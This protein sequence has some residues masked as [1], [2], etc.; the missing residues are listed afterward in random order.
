MYRLLSADTPPKP[1]GDWALTEIERRLGLISKYFGLVA[2]AEVR[3]ELSAEAFLMGKTS[4]AADLLDG[5]T[6]NESARR[7]LGDLR[8]F[9]TGDGGTLATPQ[10]AR[11]ISAKGLA[12]LPGIAA[13]IPADQREQWKAPKPPADTETTLAKLEKDARKGVAAVLNSE[14]DR[15]FKRVRATAETIRGELAKLAGPLALF[16]EKVKARLGRRVELAA[17]KGLIAFLAARGLTVDDAVALLAADADRPAQVAR[18]LAAALTQPAPSFAAHIGVSARPP[19]SLGPGA[20]GTFQLPAAIVSRDRGKIRDAARGLLDRCAEIGQDRDSPLRADFEREI[21]RMCGSGAGESLTASEVVQGLLD[22]SRDLADDHVW[23]VEELHEL[24]RTLEGLAESDFDDPDDVTALR[25]VKAHNDTLTGTV[26]QRIWAVQ[27]GCDLLGQYGTDA[28]P[29]LPWLQTAA[30]GNAPWQRHAA[31][32]VTKINAKP[33][34]VPKGAKPPV[35]CVLT[36]NPKKQPLEAEAFTVELKNNT[37]EAIELYSTLPFGTLVFMDIVIEGP[38]GKRISPEFYDRSISSPLSPQ[39]KLI[40][41]LEAEKGTKLEL[42]A[43]TRY[44]EKPEELKPGKYRV[45]V[46]FQYDKHTATSEWVP[47][48]ITKDGK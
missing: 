39:P 29:A 10:L 14:M 18:V 6:E 22:A 42:S 27:Y 41:T 36:L 23:L 11:F 32:A 3:V 5:E 2:A 38:D 8:T 20:D 47:I 40:E 21:N 35:E 24:G 16:E 4:D 12:D 28:A 7:V 25:E 34:P 44:I 19:V 43:L 37:N 26:R 9:I 17:E 48:E 30:A 13:L 1:T 46:K 31:A 33:A 45:R 15:L